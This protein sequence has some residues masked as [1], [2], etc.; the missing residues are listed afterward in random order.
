ME[1]EIN[2]N[3]LYEEVINEVLPFGIIDDDSDEIDEEGE[4]DAQTD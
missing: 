2:V 4:D 1:N 3:D